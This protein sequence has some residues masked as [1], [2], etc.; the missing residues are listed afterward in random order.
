MNKAIQSF[1]KYR[2]NED[3]I[4][5]DSYLA[6][7]QLQIIVPGEIL[8]E[9][10]A[11]LDRA[12][13][14]RNHDNFGGYG[15]QGWQSLTIYGKNSTITEHQPGPNSWTDIADRCPRTREFLQD[16]WIIDQTTGRIRFMWLQP[17]GYILPHA[18]RP[19]KRLFE[20]N[21]AITHPD[22]CRFRFLDRGDVPFTP[23]SAF[24][25]DISNRHMVV[26]DSNEIRTHIIV[27]AKLKPGIIEKSYVHS[28]YR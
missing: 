24:I 8:T 2:P 14:H 6:W 12:V 20:C 23:L 18:D 21:I 28:F 16:N 15:H 13:N 5:K 7:L 22:G 19:T 11:L 4:L 9:S 3:W 10:D 1:L 17:G 25:L 26:N 27:H